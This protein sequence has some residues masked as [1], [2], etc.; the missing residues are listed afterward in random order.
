L[1]RK[2]A[3]DEYLL[4]QMLSDPRAPAEAFGFHA[5]QAAEKLLKGLLAALQV[6]YPRTHRL[7]ELIDMA[8]S[9]GAA[10]P[11]HLDELRSLTP[12][13]VEF[14]YDALPEEPEAPL[15]KSHV[16]EAIRELHAWVQARI[17]GFA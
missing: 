4:D 16:R 9:A 8:G 3:Q 11:A 5:Q 2:A 14:R 10:V 13:A 17:Q 7:S 15:D 6:A 12:F 1:L